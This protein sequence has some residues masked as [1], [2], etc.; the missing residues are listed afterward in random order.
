M[1][2]YAYSLWDGGSD[3]TVVQQ[4]NRAF[5]LGL[6]ALLDIGIHYHGY[7][8][9]DVSAF[10][11]KLGFNASGASSLYR[12]ILQAPANYLQY[13]VGCLNFQHLRSTMQ[14]ALQEHFVLR[15]FHTAVLDAGPAPFSIL[16]KLVAQKLG[17]T[18]S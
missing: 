2:M 1:E 3:A 9:A 10:L 11:T 16:V 4:K 12:A 8:L 5:S 14:Q 18:I 6:A 7:S 17:V 13:Y 15:D